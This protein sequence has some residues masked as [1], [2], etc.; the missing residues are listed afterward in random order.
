MSSSVHSC[1]EKIIYRHEKRGQLLIVIFAY[2]FRVLESK[3]FVYISL[4]LYYIQSNCVE[5]ISTYYT[6]TPLLYY[7][8]YLKNNYMPSS[9]ALEKRNERWQHLKLWI[10]TCTL[11]TTYNMAFWLFSDSVGLW[12]WNLFIFIFQPVSG[13]IRKGRK[14]KKKLLVH[15]YIIWHTLHE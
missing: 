7:F 8:F 1:L 13:G 2:S 3:H 11:Y 10:L 15:I 4:K 14:K 6:V 12:G 5:T 9:F